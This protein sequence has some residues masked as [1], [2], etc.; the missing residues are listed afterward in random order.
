MLLSVSRVKNRAIEGHEST[1]KDWRARR[2]TILLRATPFL[3]TRPGTSKVRD[4]QLLWK[5]TMG[6]LQE[7]WSG[8]WQ[9]L[10][11]SPAILPTTHAI[12][13]D[14]T[15]KPA[16]AK[17]KRDAHYFSV[18]VNRVYLTYDR[19]FWTK[20][21]PMAL[22][23]SEFQYDG[24][25]KVVPF[26]VG[27]TLLESS[28][29]KL[30]DTRFMLHDTRVAGLH[31]YKGDGLKLTVILYCVKRSDLAKSLLKVVE[32][33][34]SA[35]DLS[36]ALAAHLKIADVLVETV[37]DLIGGDD[38]NQ[39]LIGFRRE[40]STGDDFKPGYFA[41]IEDDKI[42]VS[43]LW[44]RGN[45][46]LYGDTA[47]AAKK[48]D[49]HNYVLY[50]IGQETERDDYDKLAPVGDLWKQVKKEATRTEDDAWNMAKV[51]MSALYQAMVLSADLTEEHAGALNDDLVK[52]MRGMH[53]RALEN[54]SFSAA[55]PA[56]AGARTRRKALD[57]LKL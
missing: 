19:Q 26:V 21:A 50:S 25:N 31:P 10:K 37:G 51:G 17:F 33:L 20:F 27:P 28:S 1:E 14:H 54:V 24:E 39:P 15:D 52:R 6:N 35:V 55:A 45:D 3:T 29:V 8:L 38:E 42:D 12:P 40:F 32:R 2:R 9:T 18:T 16:G 22:A 7:W 11:E 47:A 43:K 5:V 36:H 44:V 4:T 48:F 53:E 57:I 13:A 34:T 23:V 41:L 49:A 30:P 56:D 46:L